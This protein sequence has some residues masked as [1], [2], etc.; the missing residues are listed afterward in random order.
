MIDKIH[1]QVVKR[2]QPY[3]ITRKSFTVHNFLVRFCCVRL[4]IALELRETYKIRR[5]FITAAYINDQRQS[6]AAGIYK[7][8]HLGDNHF[9]RKKLSF[10]VTIKKPSSSLRYF[11][12]EQYSENNRQNRFIRYPKAK[13]IYRYTRER[14]ETYHNESAVDDF[15][16]Q[17]IKGCLNG[18]Q[19]WSNSVF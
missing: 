12:V 7:T 3:Q 9:C 1:E 14:C 11:S 19:E 2:T 5:I 18:N 8:L 17:F 6:H 16:V 15:N 10:V 4:F 13:F